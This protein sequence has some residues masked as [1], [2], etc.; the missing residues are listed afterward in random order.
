VLTFDWN[1]LQAG[2]HV[3]AHDPR[4]AEM[5][6]I[7]GVVIGVDTRKRVDGVGIRVGARSGATA[8]L[9]PSH[10]VVHRD[11]RDPTEPWWR[12]QELAE[13]AAAPL[14]EP[15]TTTPA[16]ADDAPRPSPVLGLIG[17]TATST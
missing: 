6:L 15:W 16:G 5:T 13:R 8:V 7:D 9:W 10:L 17:P 2:N 4:T 3:L 11:P 1:A 12:C 14:H